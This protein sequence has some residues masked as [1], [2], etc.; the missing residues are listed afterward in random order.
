MIKKENANQKK[1][2]HVTSVPPHTETYSR[3]YL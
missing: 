3:N 2:E 1:V